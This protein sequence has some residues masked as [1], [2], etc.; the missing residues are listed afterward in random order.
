M[1][2]QWAYT[3]TNDIKPNA[4]TFCA[5]RYGYTLRVVVKTIAAWCCCWCCVCANIFAI[6]TRITQKRGISATR[7]QYF[8]LA[9]LHHWGIWGNYTRREQEKSASRDSIR[10]IPV[11]RRDTTPLL[12][13]C[14]GLT[15]DRIYIYIYMSSQMRVDAELLGFW[16]QSLWSA[17]RRCDNHTNQVKLSQRSLCVT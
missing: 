14:E 8:M 15:R 12:V 7:R 4:I 17:I 16:L 10:Y 13:C 11:C 5:P 3:E 2:A 1:R 9:V 6:K